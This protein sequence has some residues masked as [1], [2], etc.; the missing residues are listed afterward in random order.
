MLG[1]FFFFVTPTRLGIPFAEIATKYNDDIATI[2]TTLPSGLFAFVFGSANRSESAEL[3]PSQVNNFSHIHQFL[4][5][6]TS[7]RIDKI[8]KQISCGV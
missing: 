2:A 5:L 4:S 3:L 6:T 7:R 8:I 1:R